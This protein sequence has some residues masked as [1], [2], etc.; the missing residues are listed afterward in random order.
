MDKSI[1]GGF[2]MGHMRFSIFDHVQDNLLMLFIHG[3]VQFLSRV[4]G[5]GLVDPKD[6]GESCE[7]VRRPL[8]HRCLRR[9]RRERGAVRAVQLDEL[10]QPLQRIAMRLWRL[11][12]RL[13]CLAVSVGLHQDQ[14]VC[15]HERSVSGLCRVSRL[16]FAFKGLIASCLSR[17]CHFSRLAS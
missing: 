15:K 8:W 3:G 17:V 7:A 1:L 11:F 13:Q 5:N 12:D 16:I 14:S 6:P 4:H 9:R 2:N 10:S